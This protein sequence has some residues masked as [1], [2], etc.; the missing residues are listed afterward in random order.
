MNEAAFP[1]SKAK[2]RNKLNNSFARFKRRYPK[3]V[4][5]E[6]IVGRALSRS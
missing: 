5:C 4:N 3:G 1:W 6:W 2:N